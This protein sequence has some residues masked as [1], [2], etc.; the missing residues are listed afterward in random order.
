MMFKDIMFRYTFFKK[1]DTT[2]FYGTYDPN[3]D[4]KFRVLD[5]EEKYLGYLECEDREE[6][7]KI[8]EEIDNLNTIDDL[9]CYLGISAKVDTNIE[10]IHS[11]MVENEYGSIDKDY[12]Y[13][14]YESE[15][16]NRLGKY[17]LAV[18]EE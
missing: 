12:I 14:V 6:A 7:D 1:D 9:L 10:R 15:Y 13:S 2:I 17:Y 4:G 3:G 18:T 11:Y 8:A 5:S 16:F